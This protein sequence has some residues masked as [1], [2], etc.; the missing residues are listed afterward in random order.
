MKIIKDILSL[1][2]INDKI[3]LIGSSSNKNLKYKTDYDAQEIISDMDRNEIYEKFVE[4]FNVVKKMKH[5]FIT[6]FKN[7]VYDN[8]YP[9]RWKHK[10]V[11]N[12]YIEND[13]RIYYFVE[14]LDLRF[15]VIKIDILAFDNSENE[16]IEFSCNYYTK[17]MEINVYKSLMIDAKKYYLE[18]KFMKMLKRIYSISLIKGNKNVKTLE[19]IFNSEIGLLYQLQ[20]KVQLIFR[21]C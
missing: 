16:F 2:S 11:L 19:K 13:D 6:D 17:K 4:M 15:N 1:M 9:I 14:Q 8:S 10:D 20:H 18:K 21:C 3:E 5:V 12:G 7:G